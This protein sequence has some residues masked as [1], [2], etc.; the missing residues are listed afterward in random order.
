MARHPNKS[1]G[2][3]TF[4]PTRANSL[5]PLNDC[6]LSLT[7]RLLR[8]AQSRLVKQSWGPTINAHRSICGLG[9]RR[10]LVDGPEITEHYTTRSQIGYDTRITSTPVATA[11]TSPRLIVSNKAENK[12]H[13][14][15]ACWS[16]PM[17]VD[18]I[19]GASVPNRGSTCLAPHSYEFIDIGADLQS[20]R[21][22]GSRLN[23][24]PGTKRGI[25]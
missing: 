22:L 10:R 13:F 15:R 5:A 12:K 6:R 21:M 19:F 11:P 17:T 1:G 16:M 9:A 25:S 14:D 24:E 8:K 7:E 23:P 2:N 4:H 20:E 3:G 18:I